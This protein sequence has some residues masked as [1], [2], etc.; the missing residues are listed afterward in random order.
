VALAKELATQG[1][2][3][4][5]ESKDEEMVLLDGLGQRLGNRRTILLESRNFLG[6]PERIAAA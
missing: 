5:A 4:I 6:R 3:E 1:A 2:I